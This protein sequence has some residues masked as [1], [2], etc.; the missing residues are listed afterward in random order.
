[1]AA[2]ALKVQHHFRQILGCASCSFAALTDLPVDAKHA[3]QPAIAEEDRARATATDKRSF[4]AEVRVVGGNLEL[5]GCFAETGVFIEPV[6]A[7]LSWAEA[8]A[9]HDLPELL[10]AFLQF[11]SSLQ[12]AV[13]WLEMWVDSRRAG[14]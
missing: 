10:S 5:C 1:V 8:A 7:A 2:A 11:T 13:A 9:L 3:P 6:G 12:L 14:L 4:F